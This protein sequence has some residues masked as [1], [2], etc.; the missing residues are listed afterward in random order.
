[1][2]EQIVATGKTKELREKPGS[3]DLLIAHYL[4]TITKHDDPNQTRSF[5]GKAKHSNT[6]N[7]AVMRLLAKNNI[8]TA[9]VEK[10][11]DTE[12]VTR[13]CRMLP[14]ELITRRFA[15][16]SYLNR[17]PG[18]KIGGLVPHRFDRLC[19]EFFLKTTGGQAI[20]NGT[21]LAENLDPTQGEE[22]PFIAD[23]Y[24]NP[25]GLVHP[26]QPAPASL[27][28]F[29]DP[30]I[31]FGDKWLQK[32]IDIEQIMGDVF[33]VLEAEWNK[34]G[35]HLIDMKI[36]MGFTPDG[37]I[38]VTDVIDPDSWRLR[39]PNWT[40][41]LDKQAFRDGETLS[42]VADKYARVAQL[43]QEFDI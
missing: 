32:V 13:K 36:E 4:D 6:V 20:F 39:S 2:E 1:M 41:Q 3:D 10:F 42:E 35:L 12:F 31:I 37:Q 24:A 11:S 29:V 25:W 38:V 16:G 21:T 5:D 7:A 26:K 8:P 18:F 23:H 15:Y 34:Q 19:L 22:D 9:F 28:I 17:C 40:D 43:V 33:M 14:L 30:T 27:D